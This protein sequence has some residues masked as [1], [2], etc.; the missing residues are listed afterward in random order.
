MPPTSLGYSRRHG[1]GQRFG[2]CEH[3]SPTHNL[4]QVATYSRKTIRSI[5]RG[6]VVENC[7]IRFEFRANLSTSASIADV[8]GPTGTDRQTWRLAGRSAGYEIQVLFAKTGAR[9][10]ARELEVWCSNAR[11]KQSLDNRRRCLLK[12]QL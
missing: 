12:R 5:F 10:S 6:K 1:L 11:A 8:P 9:S 3:L 2:I 7:A 4:S